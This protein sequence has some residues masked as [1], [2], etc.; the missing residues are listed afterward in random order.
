MSKVR[1]NRLSSGKIPVL[2]INKMQQSPSPVMETGIA[3]PPATVAG[4][5]ST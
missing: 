3:M 4:I 1:E 2:V 5:D